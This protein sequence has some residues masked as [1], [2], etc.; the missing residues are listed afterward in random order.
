MKENIPDNVVFDSEKQTYDAA[1]RP[2]GTNVGA[3][4]ITTKDTATWKNRNIHKVNQ[5]FRARHLELQAS[6]QRMMEQFEYN[7][8]VYNAKFNFEPIIGETYHLYR[9]KKSESFL[10]VI[11]PSECNFDFVG[12][13]YL[14]ADQIWNKVSL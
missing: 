12:S 13:F 2:Y 9:D 5:Q 4:S 7:N 10:S 11:A 14:N 3:P 6:H 1:L 8:L